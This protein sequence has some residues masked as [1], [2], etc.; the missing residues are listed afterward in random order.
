MTLGSK[1]FNL[2]MLFD[3]ATLF[4]CLRRIRQSTCLPD[5]FVGIVLLA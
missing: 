2:Y 1:K 4:V 5:N 3:G